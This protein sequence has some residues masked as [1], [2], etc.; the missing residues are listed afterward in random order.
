M[1]D[2]LADTELDNPQAQE[3]FEAA[4]K[5]ALDGEGPAVCCEVSCCAMLCH[6][7][8]HCCAM[9]CCDVMWAQWLFGVG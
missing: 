2:N 8:L 4:V 5:A 1:A 7:V 9:L 6:A 3:R